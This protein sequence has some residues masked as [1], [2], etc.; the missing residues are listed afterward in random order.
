MTA[1]IRSSEVFYDA[2]FSSNRRKAPP[3]R[4]LRA[5]RFLLSHFGDW[6]RGTKEVYA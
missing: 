5:V 1:P 2:N 6:D 4:R 3:Y